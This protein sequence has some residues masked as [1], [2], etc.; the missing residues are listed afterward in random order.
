[1]L[2]SSRA[3][4]RVPRAP[5]ACLLGRRGF[6]GFERFAGT[7]LNGINYTTLLGATI[8]SVALIYP[9]PSVLVQPQIYTAGHRYTG[10]LNYTNL[11]AFVVKLIQ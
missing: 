8:N 9:S 2:L 10:G 3:M 4:L 6:V 11:D 7:E 5:V 1:M